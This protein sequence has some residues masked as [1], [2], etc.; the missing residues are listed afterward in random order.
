[1]SAGAAQPPLD[2]SQLANR[3]PRL[4]RAVRIHRHRY[5]DQRW[6]LL[7]DPVTG[8]WQ[9]LNASAYGLVKLLDGRCTLDDAR[10]GTELNVDEATAVLDAL[11]R[12]E[13]LDW[14]I[15]N[16]A[17]AMHARADA[18]RKRK[19][20]Q[21][22]L[23]PFSI[24]IPLFDPDRL[25]SR[26]AALGRALFSLGGLGAALALYVVAG[27]FAFID[28]PAISGY[29]SARGF[30]HY[31][32]LLIPLVYVVMK[33]AH[34]FAHGLA[35]KRWGAEVRDMGF[36][37]LLLIPIPY[38][39]TSAAWA[40][41]EKSRRVAVGAAGIL[42]ELG[43]AAIATIV[44]VLVEPG[45][46]KDIAYIAMLLGTVSTLLF[47]GNPLLRFDGYYVL[48][49][50][51]EIPNL[52]PRA[53]R[54]WL[55]LAER[56]G[57]GLTDAN[58]PVAARG[59]RGWFL[60]Y[61]AGSTLYRLGILFAIALFVAAELPVLGFALALSV[62]TVQLGAPLVR[63]G[64]FLVRS[65]RLRGLR[66]RAVGVAGGGFAFTVV[67]LLALPMP[68]STY[69]QGVVWLPEHA[70]I[71]AGADGVVTE[72]LAANDA[73][74]A[75]GT[76]LA[77]IDNPLLDARVRALEWELRETEMRRNVARVD[78]RVDA[79]VLADTLSRLRDD[80]AA[81]KREAAELAIKTPVSGRLVV[82]KVSHLAGRYVHKGD[83]VAYVLESPAPTIRAVVPQTVIDRLRGGIERTQVRL[84]EDPATTLDAVVVREIPAATRTLPSAALGTLGGGIIAVDP[85]DPDGTAATDRLYVVD[86]G[87]DA[88]R[89]PVRVGG[90][91]HVRFEHPSE[92]LGFR[93]YR[94]VRQLLLSRLAV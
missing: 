81:L 21:Q 2:W 60:F 94:A 57:F 3:T 24:R 17:D 86:L 66:R 31:S 84:A 7:R 76:T 91:A 32:L 85:A 83:V 87:V 4:R 27:V 92:P 1:M 12:A 22:V 44:F 29:W 71:R 14:G 51:L 35:A 47:N 30:T 39:D 88:S 15:P 46:I 64:R 69:A 20:L 58:S 52:S 82:P 45:I 67:V 10:A 5:R 41:A 80:L 75:A 63:F 42:A 25:L 72:L 8:Q 89:H 37:L 40:F 48:S 56:Y 50:A 74:V 16:D 78:D 11:N 23:T 33:I 6:Y 34:E 38:V 93:L 36:V 59:E 9:R 49:D 79:Q 68:L 53:T 19:R 65:P 61:G 28:W 18:N 26:Y 13:M 70:R 54:Y 55:Y 73:A 62:V 90:R 77:R 43:L